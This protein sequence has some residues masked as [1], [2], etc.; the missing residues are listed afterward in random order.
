MPMFYITQMQFKE[1]G[2]LFE[3]GEFAS[4]FNGGGLKSNNFKT[5][6]SISDM[7]NITA[8]MFNKQFRINSEG[9]SEWSKAQIEAKANA[10][11]LTESLKNE[12]LAMAS[13]ATIT[14]KLRTGK[15]TW[16]KAI[17]TAG[18]SIND[19]GDALIKSGKLSKENSEI[20][21]R[22]IDQGDVKNTKQRM[23]DIVNEVDGLADSFVNLESKT[24]SKTGFFTSAAN[25]GK[26]LLVSLKAIAPY[27]AAITAV[28]VAVG[29]LDHALTGYSRAQE[30]LSASSA[31]Y[32]ET[33]S[34]LQ[35]LNSQL[36][37]TKSR[38]EELQEIHDTTGL[39]FAQ[40][41]ELEK[42]Q[43][44]NNELQRQVD[45][46]KSLAEIEA[47][48]VAEDAKKASSTEQTRYDYNKEKY[49]F[50]K[51]LWHDLVD[52]STYNKIDE[53]GNL[54]PTSNNLE[55]QSQNNGDTTISGQMK[56]NID[57]LKQ[58]KKELKEVENKLIDAPKDSYLLNQQKNLQEQ[59]SETT[60]E[61]GDQAET[62]Q[63]WIASA[64]DENGNTLDGMQS[65]V[66][67]VSRSVQ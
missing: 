12:V 39:T 62:I 67:D 24:S 30:N 4:L 49:G 22:V 43:E 1:I 2:S 45:L 51:G 66:R 65:Y 3:K 18:D 63:Q 37:E 11:G 15:L 56:G 21:K 10:I 41:S 6:S 46:K 20:L 16:A 27:A 58:Y 61:L 32:E 42:L 57:A 34:E 23:K 33:K 52:N 28:V 60:S 38:I 7:Q 8:E 5:A 26:G 50:W 59:I 13:D 64:K 19:V 48:Q 29:A 35:S 14:D 47:K 53:K 36:D 17:D 9:V 54:V 55:W 40:E 44:T 25:L 31:K